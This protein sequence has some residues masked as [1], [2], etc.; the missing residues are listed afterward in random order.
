MKLG[1]TIKRA[2]GLSA[3]LAVMFFA[4]DFVMPPNWFG[5]AD[6]AAAQGAGG[7]VITSPLG[8]EQ[9]CGVQTANG[10]PVNN[11]VLL[12]T[13]RNSTGYV[14]TTVSGST[15]IPSTIN[16][17]IITAQPSAATL[18]LPATSS[19][20][21]GQMIEVVNGT[22]SAFATNAVS[23]APNSGQTIVGGNVS[24]TTL[25]AKSSVELQFSA[26]NTTWYQLR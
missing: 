21:D 4:V 7:Y 2:L 24:I 11:C 18:T 26:G 9:I 17:F 3:L 15:T 22:A 25:A 20:P 5:W 1:F 16:R 12:N 10:S 19:I 6:S 13:L 14:T 8:T 23:I